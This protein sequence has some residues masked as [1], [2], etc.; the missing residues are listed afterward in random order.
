MIPIWHSS[1]YFADLG[2]HIMPIRKFGLVREVLE[3]STLPVQILEPEPV[4]DTDLLRVHSAAY[5]EAMR[6]G[7]PLALAQSQKFPWSPA[8]SEAVRWTNGG[9]I[10]ALRGALERGVAG[11]LASGFHHSHAEHGEAGVLV[12]GSDDGGSL[13]AEHQG[14]RGG[15][16]RGAHATLRSEEVVLNHGACSFVSLK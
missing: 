13:A 15:H 16:G 3:N 2:P 1:R 10:A 11:N 8:L 5:L 9:C 14:E 6:T 12:D 7:E 4:S